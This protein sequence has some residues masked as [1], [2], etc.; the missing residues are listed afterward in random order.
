MPSMANLP[1]MSWTKIAIQVPDMLHLLQFMDMSSLQE[2]L[3]NPDL[4]IFVDGLPETWFS[5]SSCAFVP[6]SHGMLSWTEYINDHLSNVHTKAT[7]Y[8]TMTVT[9]CACFRWTTVPCRAGPELSAAVNHST[10]LPVSL[11]SVDRYSRYSLRPALL[12]QEHTGWHCI[13]RK[14]FRIDGGDGEYS[15]CFSSVSLLELGSR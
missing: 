15:C 10:I 1:P 2:A 3:P 11:W 8:D 4:S 14:S 9:I 7:G 6:P 5:S 12:I 13:D